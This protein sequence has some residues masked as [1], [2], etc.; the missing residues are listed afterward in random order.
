MINKNE[1]FLG[2]ASGIGYSTADEFSKEGATV[3]IFDLD[4]ETGKKAQ[5]KLRTD[6][7]NVT[8]FKGKFCRIFHM[9]STE[10]TIY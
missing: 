5:E 7:K 9:K 10:L 3:A 4:E 8:F 2:G 6:G 1:Q